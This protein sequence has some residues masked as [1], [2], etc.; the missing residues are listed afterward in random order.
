MTMEKSPLLAH[1]CSLPTFSRYITWIFTIFML[2]I[3]VFSV[4]IYSRHS[5]LT[6]CFSLCYVSALFETQLDHK[7]RDSLSLRR[8]EPVILSAHNLTVPL[9]HAN[10][11]TFAICLCIPHSSNVKRPT[12]AP[13]ISN[14]LSI[15]HIERTEPE[16]PRHR[17]IL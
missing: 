10:L 3:C 17:Y 2:C 9:G 1:T 15:Y 4:D 8:I 16:I 14:M 11:I 12:P 5:R 6:F 7:R 13:P